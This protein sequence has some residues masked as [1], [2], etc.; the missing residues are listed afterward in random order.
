LILSKIAPGLRDPDDV[1]ARS[2][3]VRCPVLVIHGRD[4]R[5]R[6]HAHGQELANLTRGRFLT[7]EGGGHIP[8]VRNPVKVNLAIRA[9]LRSVAGEADR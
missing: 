7:I 5:I 8:N 1:A 2:A 3:R 9:F 4:D 6:L